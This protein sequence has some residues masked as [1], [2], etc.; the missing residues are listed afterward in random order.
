VDGN[1]IAELLSENIRPEASM[2]TT[3]TCVPSPAE[4]TGEPT[5]PSFALVTAPS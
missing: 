1:E 5:E 3:G 4:A 2:L